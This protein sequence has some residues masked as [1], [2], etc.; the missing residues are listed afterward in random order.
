MSV[1]KLLIICLFACCFLTGCQS[2]VVPPGTV[3]IVLTAGGK[4]SLHTSGSYIAY[5]RDRVYFIDTKLK[6]YTETMKIL[7]NDNINM[8]VDVK[9]VGS[10]NASREYIRIIKEKVPAI[11]V[12]NGD[13]KG[14]QLSLD[15]FY[16]TAM[17]D[18]IRAIT[19]ETVA[20]YST[21]DVRESRGKIQETVN[22]NIR[23]RFKQL[24]YPIITTDIMISNL[25][26]PPE[27]T[28][29]RKAIKNA[30]LEN[31]KQAALARAAIAQAKREAGIAREQGKAKVEAAKADAA[32]NKIRAE[33]LTPE[34]I[35]MRQ[36]DVLEQ[37]G[38]NGNLFI[39][40]YKALD[41][42]VNAALIQQTL[43]QA[44]PAPAQK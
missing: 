2:R 8:T 10:F 30:Q 38:G 39:V 9:W 34:I 13:V 26:Y 24:G 19:R 3:V 35:Q 31:E 42:T 1:V 29:Q 37:I 20:Q 7:C 11:A 33:S 17:R 36:W 21:D 43:P 27:I 32:A 25:D 18:I 41:K 4:A 5:G 14:F 22:T 40:P 44:L 28:A 23:K 15:R 12:N 6:S 16:I